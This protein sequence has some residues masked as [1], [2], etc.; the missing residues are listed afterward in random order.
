MESLNDLVIWYTRPWDKMPQIKIILSKGLIP[1]KVYNP[2]WSD[3]PAAPCM[4]YLQDHS[5]GRSGKITIT[6][7]DAPMHAGDQV[8]K[9]S[10]DCPRVGDTAE[11][12]RVD[13]T[14]NLGLTP[15]TNTVPHARWHRYARDIVCL[16]NTGFE[17]LAKQDYE[18]MR[19]YTHR[20]KMMFALLA[21]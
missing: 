10:V 15:V 2:D 8:R 19:P 4:F 6:V 11:L 18:A 3:G 13:T 14:V 20:E 16:W 12:F 7:E 17:A 1:D 5:P 21:D 9:E